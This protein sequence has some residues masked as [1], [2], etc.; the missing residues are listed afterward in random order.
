MKNI[1][2]NGFWEI[3]NNPIS[4]VGVFPYLGKNISD[5]LEPDKI[6]Y[7]YRP[8]EELF[9]E[10]TLKSFNTAPV[11]LVNDHTMIGK[12]FTPAEEKGI[13]GVISNIR[14]DGEN[15]VGDLAIYSEDM[16]QKI[17]EGKKDLSMG[18]FCTYDLQEGTYNGQHYDA[19]QRDLRSNHV[20]LVDEGRCGSSVRV[21]DHFVLDADF[22]EDEH[23]RDEDGKFTSGNGSNHKE[24][25]NQNK[26]NKDISKLKLSEN[27][28]KSY[29]NIIKNNI[30]DKGISRQLKFYRVHYGDDE[31]I[32]NALNDFED[33]YKIKEYIQE[34]IENHDDFSEEYF[35]DNKKVDKELKV[36]EK[37]IDNLIYEYEKAEKEKE[38]EKERENFK[39]KPYVMS[40]SMRAQY[41]E[42]ID[43]S[44]KDAPIIAEGTKY[45]LK[46]LTDPDQKFDE[47]GLKRCESGAKYRLERQ[48]KEYALYK[49][50]KDLLEPLSHFGLENEGYRIS[51]QWLNAYKEGEISEEE[52][53]KRIKSEVKDTKYYNAF[54]KYMNL[55]NS[56][57]PKKLKKERTIKEI[58]KALGIKLS[59]NKQKN[60]T[61]DSGYTMSVKDT[62]NPNNSVNEEKEKMAE[63]IEKKDDE[64][65]KDEVID[66]REL[67]REIGAIAGEA[68]MSEELVKTLMQ[69]A[70]QLAYNASEES[71]ADDACAKDEDVEEEIEEEEEVKDEDEDRKLSELV[72]KKVQ[73]ALDSLNISE[74]IQAKQDLIAKVRP[75]VGDF[76]YSKMTNSDIA[77][78]ACDHLELKATKATAQDVL[79]CYLQLK[80][81]AKVY[82]SEDSKPDNTDEIIEK[83][84][85][86]E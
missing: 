58:E 35:K 38:R 47:E 62:N 56:S 48:K 77:K 83:Y 13:H 42:L 79:D 37:N 57:N 29:Q 66:K 22:K 82:S 27:I 24:S 11:P 1:D 73:D 55:R 19:I 21:Y 41:Q 9:A 60:T 76:N 3:K 45:H 67:I 46:D 44:S 2:D 5:E 68:G 8:A 15:L 81:S 52:A 4:R 80:G 50:Y 30:K 7:V 69:K 51:V 40:E 33:V 20:A 85:R 61:S 64:I 63:D 26:K 74:M 54:Y 39:K 72:E 59:K 43:K 6:Y 86:G 34:Y 70:E 84:K 53:L 18:Y 65:V 10:E 36:I 78:Y 75:L 49:E 71:K 28:Q 17:S 12:G 32:I 14:K 25:Q 16:K 31:N 23:P